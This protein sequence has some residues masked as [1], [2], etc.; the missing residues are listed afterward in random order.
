V[1]LR[2]SNDWDFFFNNFLR[3]KGGTGRGRGRGRKR[4]T[5]REGE[6]SQNILDF[7]ELFLFWISNTVK[8]SRALL[9][10]Y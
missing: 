3:K 4:G 1:I 6:Y 9:D 5:G 7:L 8:L 10:I 2:R